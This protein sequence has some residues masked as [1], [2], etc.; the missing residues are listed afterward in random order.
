MTTTITRPEPEPLSALRDLIAGMCDGELTS[1]DAARFEEFVARDAACAA[2][3]VKAMHVHATLPRHFGAPIGGI[4]AL[5]S[6]CDEHEANLA[7]SISEDT[8]NSNN[9]DLLSRNERAVLPRRRFG[10]ASRFIGLAASILLV[11]YF[12]TIAGLLVWDHV[13][14]ADEQQRVIA[15]PPSRPAALL[16]QADDAQWR[17]KSSASKDNPLVNQTLHVRS[18]LAELKFAQGA[19]VL[20][21]GPAEF[22]VRSPNSGFL[23]RGKLI[24]MVPRKAVG[25]TVFTP[26]AEIVD[27]G[28]EFGVEVDD[29]Q[30]AEIQVFTGVVVARPV[31]SSAKPG[32]GTRITAG[33]GLRV[34]G[35]HNKFTSLP[36]N[37]AWRADFVRPSK[38]HPIILSAEANSG[39]D[40]RVIHGGLADGKPAY[41]GEASYQWVGVE[42]S[43]IPR[44]LL[45]ADYVQTSD[46]DNSKSDFQLRLTFAMPATLYVF[47]DSRVESN[48][49]WLTKDFIDTGLNIGLGGAG[50]G[51][52]GES[53]VR[54]AVWKRQVPA[55]TIALGRNGLGYVGHYA[56]AAVVNF[57]DK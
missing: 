31:E 3:Y 4:A 47:M 13:R 17:S 40:Y 34:A 39:H 32:Q 10:N 33:Y 51:R 28:T 48:P 50:G 25:F 42:P 46:S 49:D 35:G 23:R 37:P 43:G 14:R 54:F 38:V 15:Q 20:L 55:G 2:Y 45:G 36:L 6:E 11:G 56:V 26:K 24:A 41:T 7:P 22:E 16:A 19:K 12:V 9:Y 27:L 57:N 30:N 5:I 53:F 18:G 44:E 8:A 1:N 21:R 29:Q 52:E